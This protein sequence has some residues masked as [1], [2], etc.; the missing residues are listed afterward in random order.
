MGMFLIRRHVEYLQLNSTRTNSLSSISAED[1]CDTS[2]RGSSSKSGKRYQ[3]IPNERELGSGKV[4][5]RL[6]GGEML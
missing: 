6:F 5:K 3:R 2:R 1:R 4:I